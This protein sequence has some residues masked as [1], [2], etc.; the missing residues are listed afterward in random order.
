MKYTRG[1][2]GFGYD[3]LKGLP[4]TWFL[5]VNCLDN[6]W[7]HGAGINHDSV[8]FRDKVIKVL[9]SAILRSATRCFLSL[10]DPNSS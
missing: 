6:M 9:A 2:I 10:V 8:F 7:T 3:R 5:N 1:I 4:S